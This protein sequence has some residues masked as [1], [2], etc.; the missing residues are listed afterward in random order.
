M[1]MGTLSEF[2]GGAASLGRTALLD[3]WSVEEGVVVRMS[4]LLLEGVVEVSAL[5]VYRRDDAGA[6]RVSGLNGS[7]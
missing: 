4:Y 7:R 1:D 3:G 6:T 2:T 5:P